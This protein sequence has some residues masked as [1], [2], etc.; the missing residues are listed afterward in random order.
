MRVFFALLILVGSLSSGINVE[1]LSVLHS[2]DAS[3]MSLEDVGGFGGNVG[4]SADDIGQTE[5]H[6]HKKGEHA[7][8]CAFACTAMIIDSRKVSAVAIMSK[9][10]EPREFAGTKEVSVGPLRRPPRHFSI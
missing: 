8:H 9:A 1:S 2:A 3:T 5:H 10:Y 6:P 4:L 7:A